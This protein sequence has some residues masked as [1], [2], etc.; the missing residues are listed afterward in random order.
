MISLWGWDHTMIQVPLELSFLFGSPGGTSFF[1][2]AQ[3][4][5]PFQPFFPRQEGKKK[6]IQLK[7]SVLK[8]WITFLHGKCLRAAKAMV[9]AGLRWAPEM[10]PVERI[11]IMTASPVEAARPI[12]VS[13]PCVFW[14]TMAVAVPANMSMKVP[15]NSAPTWF[16]APTHCNKHRM[17]KWVSLHLYHMHMQMIWSHK[18]FLK[19]LQ[20]AVSAAR[21]FVL[22]VGPKSYAC[23]T[24]QNFAGQKL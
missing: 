22:N 16:L 6:R 23:W 10:W 8:G 5:N 14:F 21:A 7:R 2:Q 24:V 4:R 18:F 12:R 19:S 1:G 20:N 17:W 9:I 11:T 3:G 13:V 15:M